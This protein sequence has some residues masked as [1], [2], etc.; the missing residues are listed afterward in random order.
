MDYFGV[1][2]FCGKGLHEKSKNQAKED[3]NVF[4]LLI[5]I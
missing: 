3:K 1:D 4:L 2:G 5:R